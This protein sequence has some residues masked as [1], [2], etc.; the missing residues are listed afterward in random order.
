MRRLVIRCV[1]VVFS[2][3]PEGPERDKGAGRCDKLRGHPHR[4]R[5]I[6]YLIGSKQIGQSD[7][8]RASNARQCRSSSEAIVQMPDNATM[9]ATKSPL[10][11]AVKQGQTTALRG[12]NLALPWTAERC[13][14][15]PSTVF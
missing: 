11:R 14:V 6:G 3:T 4:I 12:C 7:C 10:D 13:A 8:R 1:V 2:K 15:E 9:I 5:K